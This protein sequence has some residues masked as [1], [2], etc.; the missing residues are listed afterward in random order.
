MSKWVPSPAEIWGRLDRSF[1]HLVTGGDWA[2]ELP[3]KNR[4]SHRAKALLAFRDWLVK[5]RVLVCE[6]NR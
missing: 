2:L 6:D 5:N 4:I 1:S 3:E